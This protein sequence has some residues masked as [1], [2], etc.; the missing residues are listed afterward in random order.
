MGTYGSSVY[1]GGAGSGGAAGVPLGSGIIMPAYRIA[2]IIKREMLE[3]SADMYAESI[4]ELNR[5]LGSYNC[6]GR[7]IFSTSIDEYTLTADQ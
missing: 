7:K 6:D 5:L 3:P 1:S 2:G 4:P